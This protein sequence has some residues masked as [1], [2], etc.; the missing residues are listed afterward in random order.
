[1]SRDT[2]MFKISRTHHR[3]EA[4]RADERG[5]VAVIFGLVASV[6][7]GTSGLAV[8]Y[9]RWLDAHNH[10]QEALDSAVLAAGRSYQVSGDVAA[11]QE[12]GVKYFASMASTRV[13]KG[14][15]PP[16]FTFTN[17]NSIVV[18]TSSATISTSLLGLIG[19][20]ELTVENTAKATLDVARSDM[21]ISLIMS[22]G[23]AMNFATVNL[24]W[25]Y[26]DISTKL[27]DIQQAATDLVNIVM[28]DDQ[29]G[30]TTRIAVVPY[31]SYVNVGNYVS[32]VTGL[33]TSQNVVFNYYP[34]SCVTERT[35][36]NALTDA[37]PTINGQRVGVFW[38]WNTLVAPSSVF[39]GNWSIWAPSA[40]NCWFP[41]TQV[42]PLTADKV[43][44]LNAIADLDLLTLSV[45]TGGFNVNLSFAQ[46]GLN[47]GQLGVAWGYY[48]LSPNWASVWGDKTGAPYNGA[49]KKVA[50]IM[51]DGNY[52][53]YQGWIS[54]DQA[55]IRNR[56]NQI[57]TNMKQD[58]IEIFVVAAEASFN[59]WQWNPPSSD[60]INCAT[61]AN[62]Y[63]LATET[64]KLKTAFRE[65]GLRL[66]PVHLIN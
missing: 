32:K 1:M 39:S 15:P 52:D 3:T 11:A 58:G 62:H 57:C 41:M 9:S 55:G 22:V 34:V 61:D 59:N 40:N 31:S 48:A 28:T 65:I 7:L 45:N 14:M 18:G 4:F 26:L 50:V 43:T 46:L 13:D 66:R 12:A 35:G 47:A 29:S 64:D 53:T 5:H 60:L 37:D 51:G 49:T 2:D 33:P 17:N 36:A 19:I 21:E 30:A 24:G 8:D 25:G 23:F 38:P 44:V 63:F 6:L 16:T 10:M 54:L 27:Y 20:Q 56:A 42:L